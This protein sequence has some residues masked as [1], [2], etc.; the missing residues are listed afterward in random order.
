M[1][2]VSVFDLKSIAGLKNRFIC[3][4]RSFCHPCS[5][6]DPLLMKRHQDF[7]VSHVL[8]ALAALTL[9]PVYLYRAGIAS[10]FD[11]LVL[12][13]FLSPLFIAVYVS[14]TGKLS[15]AH[16]VSSLN[17][18]VFI[19]VAAGFSGGLQSFLMAWLIIV[20]LEA[21]LSGHKRVILAAASASLFSLLV[22]A[23]LG[24]LQWIANQSFHLSDDFLILFG[25]STALLYGAS[26]AFHVQRLHEEQQGQ[27]SDSEAKYRLMAD[28]AS[29]LIMVHDR[30]GQVS[31]VSPAAKNL[32]GMRP[33]DLL[34]SGIY[35]L[36]HV[37]DR[38]I[39]MTALSKCCD[40]NGFIN[41]EFRIKNIN[42]DERNGAFTWV[43]MRCQMVA[44]DEVT[45]KR[46]G[47]IISVTRDITQR[48][49]Q[50]QALID[51]RKHAEEANIA[52]TQFL[53]NMSHELR[54][55]LNAII[56]FSDVLN[57]ETFGETSSVKYKGYARLINEAG[58]HLL[59][60]VNNILD[61][62]KIEVGKFSIVPEAFDLSRLLNNSCEM[63]EPLAKEKNISIRFEDQLDGVEIIADSRAVRQMVL[64]L[65]S[66]AIK[67]S[68]NDQTVRLTAERQ[69]DLV[70]IAVRDEGIGIAG[71]DLPKLGNPFVQADSSYKREHDGVGLGLSVVKGL[72][73]LHGG[74]FSIDSRIGMWTVASI[75]LPLLAK[76]EDGAFE[77]AEIVEPTPIVR[78]QPPIDGGEVVYLAQKKQAHQ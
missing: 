15:R 14:R 21:A 36:I 78:S 61:M 62:S 27:I 18:A 47:K 64:N 41:V 39:Y 19:T 32:F 70:F 5:M 4:I 30:Q 69:G 56:G 44:G 53:A 58:L 42:Q 31:F 60:V 73:Q 29:D 75:E 77:V 1:R 43:E 51:A 13:W 33:D 3:K 66:N 12:L 59:G 72:A 57:L 9:Y 26:I 28:H 49:I 25:L 20:P 74:R 46:T 10:L 38:P 2:C 24:Q 65:L 17:L 71:D 68:F 8:S 6:G 37:T 76:T 54:T 34:G 35:E 22:I 23:G 40:S 45:T 11:V 16:L 7:I 52:K 67:F 63:I 55:P 50:E 48:K